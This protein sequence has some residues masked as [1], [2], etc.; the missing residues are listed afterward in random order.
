MKY[1]IVYATP[2]ESNR[3]FR[4]IPSHE[5]KNYQAEGSFWFGPHHKWVGR[6]FWLY[7]AAREWIETDGA[8]LVKER[9]AYLAVQEEARQ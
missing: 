2:P 3:D 7:G 5:I 8:K 6:V 9:Q 1:E 4:I